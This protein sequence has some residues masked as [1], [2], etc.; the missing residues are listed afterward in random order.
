M[1]IKF[2]SSMMEKFVGWQIQKRKSVQEIVQFELSKL[3]KIQYFMVQAEL[4]KVFMQSSNPHILTI[5]LK[6]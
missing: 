5:E 4:I 3:F 1:F 6:Y 2:Y